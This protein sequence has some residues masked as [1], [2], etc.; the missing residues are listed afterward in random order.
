[1]TVFIDWLKVKQRHSDI[2]VPDWGQTLRLEFDLESG[3]LQQEFVKGAYVDGS[4]DTRLYVRCSGGVVEVSGNP[5]KWGRLENLMGLTMMQ[6]CIEV[7]N[8]VLA[9]LGLPLFELKCC[10]MLIG[11]HGGDRVR[12]GPVISQV[13]L[14]ANL[15]V[16]R[17]GELPYLDWLS[18]QTFA[19]S[20]YDR[21]RRTTV[22]AGRLDR[23]QHQVY[24][25]GPE[26][27]GHALKWRRARSPEKLAQ[28]DEAIAYLERLAD[29]S[30]QIG[31]LRSELKLGRKWFDENRAYQN[32]EAWQ[33]KTVEQVYREN[34]EVET[35][36][37]G[38]L[39]NYGSEVFE[40]LVTAGYSE[41][42][43]G[44]MTDKVSGWL[45]GQPWDR[46]L[47]RPTRYKYLKALREHCGLD[48][49]RPC[50]VR[51]MATCIKPKVL[52]AREM[53]ITDL[54][55]WYRWPEQRGAA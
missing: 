23:R 47:A 13:H 48:L 3:E 51:A 30:E 36:N 46:G 33:E 38:A 25:K 34:Q 29:W 21:P 32:P 15:M 45:A 39:S 6:A 41:R 54:P 49:R 31:V 18:A 5:S 52:E 17:G 4:H 55:D 1:M 26:I 43:A 37:A 42:L 14:T 19:R 2:E 7:Y 9:S 40:R 22:Q 24:A 12:L 27:R 8:R 50:N 20:P 10:A 53:E 28:K 44:T 11:E 16:G 35:M